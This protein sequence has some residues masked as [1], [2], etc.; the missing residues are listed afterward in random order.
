M[1]RETSW[2]SGYVTEL[3][4]TYGY[5]RELSPGI[6]RLACMS[7]GIAPLSTKQLRY[8]ELGFGQGLSIAIHAAA[9]DGEFWGTD[10]N[11]AQVT[12]ARALVEAAGS[13][14]KLFEDSF[15]DFAAR[16]DLP[17]FDIIGLHGIW[18]W[19]S[20]E[21]SRIIVD[22]IRRKLRAGGIV[23]ISYNCL[24]GWAPAVPLRHLMKLHADLA[25]E[26]SGLLSKLDGAV[27]F[28]QQVIDSGAL[29]F[30][31]IQLLRSGLNE[32]QCSID[33]T[34]HTSSLHMIGG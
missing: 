8:L 21:N 5:Y 3:E 30:A 13:G 27:S 31:E 14:A 29:F 4:Y 7:A 6:L 11:P 9:V 15:A 25:G 24:P 33:I 32:C 23:Y 10:F 18:T 17:E 34:S 19:I 22:L 12:H 26:A 28:A 20:D 1:D 16:T 2:T